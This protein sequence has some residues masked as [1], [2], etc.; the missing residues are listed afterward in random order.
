MCAPTYKLL[1]KAAVP[2]LRDYLEIKLKIGKLIGGSSGRFEIS[3]YGE[4]SLW[5]AAQDK[6]TRILFGH[7]DE[8]ESLEAAQYKAAVCDE[9][10]QKRFKP[11]SWEAILRR[12]SIDLGRCLF[13]TTPYAGFGWLKTDVYDPAMRARARTG[14]RFD[15]DYDVINFES[16]ENPAFPLEEWD[17]AK[18][19]LPRWKFDLFYRGLFTRPAGSIYDCFDPDFHIMP[20]KDFVLPIHWPLYCGIDF[21]SPNFAA[22][23][24]YENCEEL[25]GPTKGAKPVLK[26]TGKY[27]AFAEYRPQES[28]KVIDHVAAMRKIIG[29]N[30]PDV[31]VGGAKSEGQWRSEFAAAG[32]PIWEPDQPDVEVGISRVYAAFAEDRLF[33]MDTVPHLI[34]DVQ[35]YSREVDENGDPIDMTIEDKETFHSVDS[36]RYLLSYLERK[37]TGFFVGVH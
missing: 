35:A 16:I 18:A 12:L 37:A 24:F 17:R 26:K 10:G 20:G 3:K 23:F 9:A 27:V 14:T 4:W 5:Q 19:T 15:S 36:M 33:L 28:K 1:D 32:W 25:E 34:D 22:T 8:P 29:R 11:E 30:H 21:G 13:P 6:Q 2:Y 7:A 31:C